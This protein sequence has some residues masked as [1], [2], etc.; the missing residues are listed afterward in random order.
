MRVARRIWRLVCF[1][2]VIPSHPQPVNASS[3]GGVRGVFVQANCTGSLQLNARKMSR[4]HSQL[5]K[6]SICGNMVQR[7]R[8]L[9]STVTPHESV[10]LLTAP[11]LQDCRVTC[12]M[13]LKASCY[14]APH[15]PARRLILAQQLC[16]HFATVNQ[17]PEHVQTNPDAMLLWVQELMSR[18]YALQVVA[19]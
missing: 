1:L 6:A 14:Y 18:A 8:H 16:A 3:L 12:D 5:T 19:G 9:L 13:W 10:L 17:A 4:A 7:V 2:S 15:S 11:D